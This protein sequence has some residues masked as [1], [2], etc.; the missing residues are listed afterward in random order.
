MNQPRASHHADDAGQLCRSGYRNLT[1]LLRRLVVKVGEHLAETLGVEHR[2]E[3]DPGVPD[4][5]RITVAVVAVGSGH[6]RFR[7]SSARICAAALGSA[8]A[9]TST[10]SDGK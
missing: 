4:E 5:N 2:R 6:D 9:N 7:T 3:D 10:I 1:Q 8:T